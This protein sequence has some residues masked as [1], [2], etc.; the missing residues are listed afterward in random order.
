MCFHK[1]L[2]R[3]LLL[4]LLLLSSAGYLLAQDKAE[5]ALQTLLEKYPQEKLYLLYNKESYVAGEN[6]WFNA[7]AFEGYNRSAI[8]TNL[9][10]ELYNSKKA[11]ISRKQVPLFEGEGQG[12]FALPDSLPE[13]LYYVRGYTQWM[14]NF[15]EA[16]QYMHSFRLYNTA[17]PQKLIPD[18]LAAWTAAAFPEGGT[19]IEG[20]SSKVAVRLS[21]PGVLPENWSGYVIDAAKPSEKIASFTA[22][23]RNVAVFS[24]LPEKEKKYQ[25]I[26]QDKKGK[27]QTI[28]LPPAQPS[29]VSLQVNSTNQAIFYSL[30]FKNMPAGAKGYKIIGTM[31]NVLVYKANI[32]KISPEIASAIP[33]DKLINGVLRLTVFDGSE[34]VVAERVCFVQPQQLNTG[35]PS[36]PPLYLSSTPRGVNGFDILADSNYLKYTV[37]VMDGGVHDY[38]DNDNILTSL[39]LTSDFTG[40]IHAPAR[41][42]DADADPVAL[43][44]LLISEK[45]KRFDWRAVIDGKFPEIRYTPEPYISYK[46]TV[47][48]GGGIVAN[49]TV[50]LIFYFADSTTQIHQ[51]TTDAKGSFDLKNLIFEEPLKVYY[52]VNNKKIAPK[53]VAVTF[54]SLN[55]V[56]PYKEPLPPGGYILVKRPP[57][58]KIQA[59]VARALINRNNQKKADEKFKTLEE[60]KI[61]AQG[62]SNKEKLNE[63]LSSGMFRSMNE[64]VFDFVNENQDAM[65]YQNILQWLQGR[66]AGLQVQMQGGDYVPIIR[67]SRVELYLDEMRVDPGMISSLP[68]SNIAMVKVI[69][70]GFVGGVGG[71]GG[72]AVAIYTRRG[73]TQASNAQ[74]PPSLNSGV[75]AGYDKV[76]PFY[77]PDYKD[78]AVKR[79]EK[80]SRDALY[81]N[82]AVMRDGTKPVQI[83]FYNNDDAKSIRVVIIGFSKD[84]DIP[85]FYND[86]FRL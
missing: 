73:D 53:D 60:V 16:F 49:E 85:L 37:L 3:K 13:G 45:W 64:N 68:V 57:N 32:N 77:E 81:W 23:D 47:Y 7:F 44:A 8:S 12:S 6:M 29:G 21:S 75:L 52:Q 1:N 9:T 30:Q 34:N 41:Y 58:D 42:F 5:Q 15:D 67:G 51:V 14:L 63:K 59:D 76:L 39:W 43:D 10:L 40:H 4:C 11:L 83:R 17:S 56:V 26:V 78:A 22:L 25:V 62:K 61:V 18:S 69:K 35:R 84:E 86:I 33:A 48:G 28:A 54:E 70:G 2:S 24:I 36:F 55:K 79:I 31:N 80:D 66:V 71:G 72:S 50:N 46:G 82:P 65:S 27:K 74:K 20:L 38:L 19:F